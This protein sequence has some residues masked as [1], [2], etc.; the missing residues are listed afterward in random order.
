MGDRTASPNGTE[1]QTGGLQAL[2]EGLRE[3]LYEVGAHAGGVYLFAPEEDM[4]SLAVLVGLPR[5]IIR[6]WEKVGLTAPLPAVDAL[7]THG[8]V[9]VGQAEE[10]VRDYPRT[11]ITLPYDFR[12]G[13]YPLRSQITEYGSLFAIWPASHPP[14]LTPQERDTFIGGARRLVE[15]LEAKAEQGR[16]VLPR[17]VPFT[18]RTPSPGARDGSAFEAMVARLPEGICAMDVRGRLTI[19]TDAAAELLGEPAG[20]LVGFRPWT[21]LPWLNDPV[22][23]D[24]YRAA[25][26]S[27]EP[28]SFVALRPPDRWLSFRLYPDSSGISVLITPTEV[29]KEAHPM[30]QPTPSSPTRTG[31]LYYI[32]HLASALTE[33]VGVK[34]VINLVTDQIAPA[35]GAQ[36]LALFTLDRGRHRIKLLGARG[37]DPEF[38][39]RLDGEHLGQRTPASQ[40]ATMGVPSFFM[41]RHELERVYSEPEVHLQEGMDAWAFLPLIASGRSVGSCVLAFTRARGFPLEERAILNALGGLI[42]QALERARLYDMKLELAHGLQEGLLPHTLPQVKGLS[43]AAR[44]LPGTE[45]MDIGG[46][47]YD[48]IPLSPSTAAAVIGDVQGHNVSAA[49]LMG[50]LRTAVRAYTTVLDGDPAQ[51]LT[52]TNRLLCDLDPDLFASCTYIRLDLEN[53][54]LCLALAGHPQPLLR[55][56]GGRARVLDVPSGLLLGIDRTVDY[57]MT[58]VPLPPGATLALYTDGLIEAPGVDLDE[59]KQDLAARL[60]AAGS[61]PVEEL[62]DILTRRAR[63]ASHRDDDVALF[64]LHAEEAG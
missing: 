37:F 19:V 35:L 39:R 45:G 34:D 15:L 61:R 41:S 40:A 22:Y 25:M 12:V 42:A 48:L 21:V 27:R 44:Y 33:A 16:P 64:L 50:Q 1:R 54:R 47:F 51:V 17:P 38:I 4:L 8:L 31:E 59:A 28:T 53:H 11:A 58:E 56:P 62:A 29:D 57:P 43:S 13:A 63:W 9:W 55:E 36:A 6:P 32:V 30:Y 18:F 2:A 20:R 24:R 7:R 3:V 10:M 26:M 46:D 23:E 52:R 60:T 49:A 5:E 14:T